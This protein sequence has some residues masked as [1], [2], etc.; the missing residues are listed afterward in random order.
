ML[1]NL[2]GVYIML[3]KKY[4]IVPNP[5]APL[6]WD[7]YAKDSYA[8]YQTLLSTASNDELAFQKFFEENPSFVPGA[9][10]LLGSS[11]HYPFSHSLISQPEICGTPFKRIPD[12]IWLAQDSLYFTP[13]LIEI[14]RPNKKTFTEAGVQTADFSQAL[15]QISEWK[16]ILSEPENVLNFYKSFNIPERIRDK[17]FQPQYALIYGRRS[18]FEDRPFLQK[19]RAQLVQDKV[20]LITFDRLYPDPKCDDL[21]CTKLSQREYKVLSIPPTYR[22][23]PMTAGNLSVVK[24]FQAAIS[25]MKRTS[26]E[27]KAFLSERFSY[28]HDWGLQNYKGIICPSDSE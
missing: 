7:N 6:S 22:Y 4:E 3:E 26:P 23:S 18:E 17:T 2:W 9:F 19:K 15:G 13:V 12:F 25:S 14:E 16:A 28:W 11:G 8:E 1:P 20:R 27:R 21:L 10:E 24:G 5:P